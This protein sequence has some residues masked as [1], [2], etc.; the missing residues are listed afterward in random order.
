M[1]SG[2]STCRASAGCWQKKNPFLAGED[3]DR[4]VEERH[5]AEQDG[6]QA[7]VDYIAARKETLGLLVGLQAEWSR[8]ARH[9]IFGPTTLLE[10][11]G[12]TAGHD[13]AHIQQI[14]KRI[15]GSW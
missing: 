13:R 11:V 1:W 6:F 2:K 7:M 3:T 14:W 9:A 10:L 5:Y 12:F 8:T 4:W 15:H